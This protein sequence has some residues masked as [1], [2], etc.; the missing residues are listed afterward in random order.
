MN[1]SVIAAVISESN[2]ASTSHQRVMKKVM[3]VEVVFS[4]YNVRS[5]SNSDSFDGVLP[6]HLY[7]NMLCPNVTSHTVGSTALKS[8]SKK[9]M[10]INVMTFSFKYG[11]RTYR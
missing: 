10:A 6:L 7:S 5:S 2:V 9:F 1:V 8:T 4:H 11:I 3:D